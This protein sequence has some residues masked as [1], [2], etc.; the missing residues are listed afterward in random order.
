VLRALPEINLVL[1]S[2]SEG[3]SDCN[4]SE[5]VSVRLGLTEHPPLRATPYRR[6]LPI[7]VLAG[8][9]ALLLSEADEFLILLALFEQ[10]PSFAIQPLD[11]S[12]EVFDLFIRS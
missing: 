4:Q 8:E 12:F 2:L 1:M 10:L 6:A 3:A 9:T 11:L 5:S 7:A